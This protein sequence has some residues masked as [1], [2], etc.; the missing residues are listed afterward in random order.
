VETVSV[1]HLILARKSL[2]E[3]TVAAFF[4]QLFAVRQIIAKQVPGA[5][6]IAKPDTEKDYQLSIHRGAAAVIDGTERTFLDRYGDYFWF[7]LLLLSGIGS[8]AAWLRRYINR[9]EREENTSHR[10]RLL[11]M[12]SDARTAESAQ[13]LLAL[14]QEADSIIRETLECYDSGAIEEEELAAFGLVIELLNLAIMERRTV[15]RGPLEQVRGIAIGQ[16]SG[17]RG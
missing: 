13:D 7:G 5:A 11:D 14:Q 4:R 10:K 6:L 17:P 9:D 16:G 8:A 12:V 3:T 15:L 2:S 1:S